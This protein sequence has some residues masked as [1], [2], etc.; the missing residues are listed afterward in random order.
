MAVEYFEE[1][2]RPRIQNYI[3]VLIADEYLSIKDLQKAQALYNRS[4]EMYEKESWTPLVASIKEKLAIIETETEAEA[5]K[6]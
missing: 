4:L 6:S 2:N 5:D 3:S 1:W